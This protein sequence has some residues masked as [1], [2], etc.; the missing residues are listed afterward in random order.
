MPLIPGFIDSM[1]KYKDIHRKKN[2]DYSGDKGAF[3]NFEF[4]ESI[5]NLFTNTA[6]KVYAVFVAV[7][8]ARLAVLLS[9]TD[10][11]KNEPIEDSFDDLIVYATIWKCAYLERRRER[12]RLSD[13]RVEQ[14][15]TK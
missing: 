9:K 8:L 10:D 2:D 4:C 7:K 3:F 13:A 14:A 15:N 6:D 5:A 12:P 11:P 1:D